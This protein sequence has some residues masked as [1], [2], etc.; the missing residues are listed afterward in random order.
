MEG[1]H[2]KE[3][4]GVLYCNDSVWLN[5]EEDPRSCHRLHLICAAWAPLFGEDILHIRK[6]GRAELHR[7]VAGQGELFG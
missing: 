6:D 1:C 2:L 7:E 4:K 3:K 5:A